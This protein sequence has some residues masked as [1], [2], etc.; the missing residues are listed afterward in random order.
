MSRAAATVMAVVLAATVGGCDPF[1]R[2]CPDRA[3]G[4]ERLLA[5]YNA[6]A[7]AVPRVWARAELS[8]TMDPADG[9]PITWDSGA[10]T[11]LLLLAKGPR[12]LGPHDFVLIGRE[13]A[14]MELFR[15]GSSTEDGV[16]YFWY[17]IGKHGGAWLGSQ[18]LAGAPG[19]DN[20]PID[21]MQMLG[22]LAVTAL[23]D[24][25]TRLPAVALSMNDTPGECAYVVTLI[26]RQPLTNR[27]LFRREILFRWDGE[28]GPLRPREVR[29]F[30][31]EGRRMMTASLADY[32]PID[33]SGLDD[34]PAS[35]PV[36]P[37]DID[38]RF[39]AAGKAQAFVRRIRLRLS[40]MTAEDVW[41]REAA[42]F[43]PPAGVPV[44]Q[45]DRGI[46]PP[47][48]RGPGTSRPAGET[49]GEGGPRP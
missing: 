12:R 6:N 28:P 11:C 26:D 46:R 3:V 43:R 30:N 1:L 42:Q 18:A 2:A 8:V 25:L 39:H 16:Y 7:D 22:V 15:I 5:E 36:M 35:E 44:Q 38:M 45:V 4:L 14:N 31:A 40:E 27:V 32:A 48:R 33:T 47:Y 20:L 34:P 19:I 29:V 9:P 49:G 23:P 21:P 24:D 10:P 41:L 37:T 17:K 13:T